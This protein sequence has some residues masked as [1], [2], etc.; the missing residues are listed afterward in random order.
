[1]SS[2]LHRAFCFMLVA[3]REQV[4]QHP[5]GQ[6]Q[7]VL[8]EMRGKIGAL[9][10]YNR[11]GNAL[12]IAHLQ[13]LFIVLISHLMLLPW[14]TYALCGRWTIL[15]TVWSFHITMGT[16]YVGCDMLFYAKGIVRINLLWLVVGF[17]TLWT[18][19][20]PFEDMRTANLLKHEIGPSLC[21]R[22]FLVEPY[23]SFKA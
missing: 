2:K 15:L 7:A 8:L 21:L 1:M 13:I 12:H 23:E 14:G 19:H 17:E 22:L 3:H 9:D 4:L 6:F 11:D 16:F 10:D 5:L 18:R 20:A